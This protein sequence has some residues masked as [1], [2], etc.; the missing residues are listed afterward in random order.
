MTGRWIL[1]VDLDQFVAAVEVRRHPELRGKPVV[2]G[3]SG[4]PTQARQVV[5]TASY[6]AR[7]FGVGSG[8]P[9]RMAARK[10]PEA[11]FLPTDHA[12][13]DAASAEVMA[14]LR[15]FPVVVEVLGWDEA[16]V[17]AITDDPEQLANELRAAVQ[18]RTGLSCSIGVGDSKVRAKIATGFAKPAG[19]YRLT[20]ANWAEVMA[21]RPV[22]ELWGIGPRMTKN[23][24][25]LGLE[26]VGQLAAADLDVLRERFGPTMGG[27]YGA[28]GRG[29]GG[30]EVSD[31]PRVAKGRSKETTFP[32]DLTERADIEHWVDRLAREVTSEVVAD[33]RE[34]LRVAVKIR[35][36]SFYTP[37][38]I[39]KL[40]QVTT[41]PAVVAATA[42]DVL[43]KFDLDRPVRLLGV[44]VELTDPS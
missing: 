6:E 38:K 16:F 12:A 41:D 13:Y 42:L 37:T 15:S 19:V 31:V 30:G 10:C 4:D 39:R 32:A 9:L 14:V 26:T 33:G 28:L 43:A 2:V 25:E 34:V 21:H 7:A 5:A 11:V 8:M 20:V 44:R 18:T 40:P 1:H 36:K 24:A 3:G 23:L 29:E 17:G 35:Y 27:W 22:R